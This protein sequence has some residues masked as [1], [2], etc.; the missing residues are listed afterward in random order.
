M[1]YSLEDIELMI[2]DLPKHRALSS[3]D[4]SLTPQRRHLKAGGRHLPIPTRPK[5]IINSLIRHFQDN[6]IELENDWS[7]SNI[8]Y[9]L[10][11]VRQFPDQDVERLMQIPNIKL[12]SS[13]RMN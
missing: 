7:N 1:T 10:W 12:I 4:E 8:P 13:G 6:Q 5:K 3:L 2:S 9:F 11:D